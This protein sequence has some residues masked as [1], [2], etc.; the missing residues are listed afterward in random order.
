MR[1]T[2]RRLPISAPRLSGPQL[3]LRLWLVVLGAGLLAHLAL[4]ALGPDGHP[5]PLLLALVCAALSAPLLW[6][7]VV[8]PLRHHA[9]PAP[10]PIVPVAPAGAIGAIVPL[11]ARA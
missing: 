7:A 10:A 5:G 1:G 9:Q 3:W 6:A 11:T 4:R 8:R 2:P